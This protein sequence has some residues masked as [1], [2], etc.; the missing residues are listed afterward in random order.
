MIAAGLAAYL[1][2]VAFYASIAKGASVV[3][4]RLAF[5]LIG[6]TLLQVCLGLVN[7]MLLAPIPIQL[8]HLMVADLLWITFV[9]FST[10]ILAPVDYSVPA[11]TSPK[12]AAGHLSSA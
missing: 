10:E 3:L 8:L 4:K 11:R 5:T 9:L 2:V 7:I 12:P 1:L 6:L